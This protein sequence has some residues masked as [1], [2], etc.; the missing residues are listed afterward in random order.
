VDVLREPFLE[1]DAAALLLAARDGA[2]EDGPVGT[3]LRETL[4]IACIKTFARLTT[5]IRGV[6]AAETA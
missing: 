1:L 3:H 5:G 6:T 2:L 4:A